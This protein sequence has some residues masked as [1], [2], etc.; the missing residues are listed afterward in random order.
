MHQLLGRA[1]GLPA[2]VLRCSGALA[3]RSVL[4]FTWPLLQIAGLASVP[5][6]QCGTGGALILLSRA[7]GTPVLVLMAIGA[8]LRFRHPGAHRTMVLW[9]RM[10]P[11]YVAYVLMKRRTRRG[12]DDGKLTQEEVDAMWAHLHEWGGDKAYQMVLEASGYIVKVAQVLASKHD[13]MPEPWTRK[14]SPL[15]DSMPP[16]PWRQIRK[17]LDAEARNVA[18]AG[19]IDMGNGRAIKFADIFD[20]VEAEPLASASVAQVHLGRLT[21]AAAAALGADWKCG[22]AIVL[23]VQHTTMKGLMD[24]DINTS[25]AMAEFMKNVLPFE[26]HAIFE[27]LRGAVPLEFDF[28]REARMCDAIKGRME[29]SEFASQI[30]VPLAPIDLCTHRLLTQEFVEGEPFS[31]LLPRVGDEPELRGKLRDGLTTIIKAYGKMMIYDGLFHGDPHPGNIL[32]R[33]GGGFALLDFG[34]CKAM[35]FERQVSLARLVIAMASAST[36]AVALAMLQL[37]VSFKGAQQAPAQPHLVA[38]MAY[39]MFDTRYMPEA[40]V[41]PFGDA[42][43]HILA[44][45]KFDDFPADLW[46]VTRVVM[47]L[48]GLSSRLEADVHA[49]EL[50]APYAQAVLEDLAAAKRRSEE[51]RKIDEGTEGA[52]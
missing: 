27:E 14:L 52:N 10:M 29:A 2:L 4:P 25:D 1:L 51:N 8:Y 18:V 42:E 20:P 45:I 23:K 26:L 39:M 15:F 31:K 47:L 40:N 9:E 7:V 3:L 30:F 38:K 36:A 21:G 34:Q 35:Q 12:K 41:N 43:G 49:A 5:L 33:P 19:K 22:D 32:L 46:F 24:V 37:G 11:I 48:R 17:A 50:W 44:S 13:V 28:L 6:R 16:R